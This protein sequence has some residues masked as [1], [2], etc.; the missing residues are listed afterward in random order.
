MRLRSVFTWL[1]CSLHFCGFCQDDLSKYREEYQAKTLEQFPNSA[2][3][4]F[5]PAEKFDI[6]ASYRLLKKGKVISV[7]TSG[8]KIKDYREYAEVTFRLDGKKHKF[9][10]YQ[11]VPV[12]PLYKNHLFLPLKDLTAPAETYGGGRYMDLSTGDFRD[13]KVRI[14]FN[15]LYN[16]Y[17][18]FSDGWNCPIPPKGN[19][20]NLRIEA[21][22]KLP[23]KTEYD[24]H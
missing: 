13:G 15:R 7:P 6:R 3:A 24:Q 9:T 17:C 23:L 4:F 16:P 22:E 2:Q 8:T 20:L 12:L 1:F 21:G 19:H 11:P 14:N 10:V 5:E 18:A